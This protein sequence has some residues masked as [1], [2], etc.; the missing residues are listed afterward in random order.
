MCPFGHNKPD[1]VQVFAITPYL[2]YPIIWYFNYRYDKI[3]YNE[4]K[5]SHDTIGF[6]LFILLSAVIVIMF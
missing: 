1:T 2:F 3:P 5:V 6:E 4:C